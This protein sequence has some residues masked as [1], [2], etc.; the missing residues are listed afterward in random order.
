MKKLKPY[1]LSPL[2]SNAI[3]DITLKFITNFARFKKINQLYQAHAQKAATEFVDSIIDELKLNILADGKDLKN[4]PKQGAFIAVSN[5]PLGGIEGL[6]L[7]K[8]FRQYRPDIKIIVSRKFHSIKPLDQITLPLPDPQSIYTISFLKNIYTHLYNGHPIIIFPAVKPAKYNPKD[9]LISDRKW[10][11][12]IIRLVKTV[13]YPVLPVFVNNKNSLLFHVLGFLHPVFQALVLEHEIKKQKNQDILI[14]IGKPVQHTTLTKFDTKTATR[15]IRARI[16]ALGANIEVNKFK[17]SSEP[18]ILTTEEDKFE[19][20]IDPIDPKLIKTQIDEAKTNY[21]QFSVNEMDVIIAPSY[22]IPDVLTEIGRLREI[23]FRAIGEGSG[24][25]LDLDEYDL[26]YQHLIIWNHKTNEIVGAYRMGKGNELLE[27]FGLSGFYTSTLFKYKKEMLPI[28]ERSL[29]LGRA[30]IIP[31]YQRKTLPLFLLWK[32]ILY[33]LLKNIDYQYLLGPVSISDKFSDLSK[34]LI[35]NFFKEH[36]YSPA[37]S[38]FVKPRLPYKSKLKGID[39]DVLVKEIGDNINKLDNII[40]D[41]EGVGIPVLF[42]KYISLGAKILTFNV[43]PD[44]NYTI[45]GLMLLDLY[46][47]PLD[48]VKA[49]AKELDA[50]QILKRFS[51]D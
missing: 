12:N 51:A 34:T 30:F 4:I 48:T 41:I 3:T 15:Y 14:R 10:N 37:Y 6:A 43:D 21:L 49:L 8:L 27:K 31:E 20:I 22:E 45:D 1:D 5:F 47:V 32:G 44:F 40:K 46:N 13:N 38:K 19:P 28:L 18:R 16:F 35:T 23:T 39:K 24:K 25:S 2:S 26:Y 11:T 7:Y 9:N 50:N 17:F 36:Y 29:E 42:K 33:Y